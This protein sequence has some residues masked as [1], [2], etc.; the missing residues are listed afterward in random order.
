MR[1]DPQKKELES[2]S[3]RKK[4][5]PL[6]W[7]VGALI[8]AAFELYTWR[9]GRSMDDFGNVGPVDA[10]SMLMMLVASSV[11]VFGII[12]LYTAIEKV[13]A[14]KRRED[15]ELAAAA[16]ALEHAEQTLK[17]VEDALE[18][19]AG[20]AALRDKIDAAQ[21][22]IDVAQDAVEDAQEVVDDMLE[23]FDRDDDDDDDDGRRDD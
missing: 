19:G 7:I 23:H 21:E 16:A 11:T 22:A 18:E 15:A 2:M 8:V 17:D 20:S 10:V 13:L 3:D 9:N 12:F 6:R 4:K 5:F 1:K 14:D